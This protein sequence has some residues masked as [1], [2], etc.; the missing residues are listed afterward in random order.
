MKIIDLINIA[1]KDTNLYVRL[2][3]NI[4]RKL[5]SFENIKQTV[6]EL[7]NKLNISKNRIYSW[8]LENVAF[9]LYIGFD[10]ITNH[11]N[12][13]PWSKFCNNVIEIKYG[14]RSRSLFTKR[15]FPI[16][17]DPYYW[18]ILFA[19][20]CDGS[21][22]SW[23][24]QRNKSYITPSYTS[25]NKEIMNNF[26]DLVRV[27]FGKW[28]A[29]IY[30]GSIDIPP[31]ID[32]IFKTAHKINSFNTKSE[33]IKQ[34][35]LSKEFE[36]EIKNLEKYNKLAILI[37]FLV[38]EG[39]KTEKTLNPR[40]PNLTIS[41]TSKG[42][43][44]ILKIILS[45]LGINYHIIFRSRDNPKWKDL[46]TVQILRGKNR[47]NY[48]K[49]KKQIDDIVNNY[50]LCKL[51]KTQHKQL[52]LILNYKYNKPKPE[53]TNSKIPE[54]IIV[55]YIRNKKK[56]TLD[57][58]ITELKKNNL[59]LNI[60]SILAT[61]NKLPIKRNNKF[62]FHTQKLDVYIPYNKE[63]IKNANNYFQALK[64]YKNGNTIAD[65]SRSLN[66]PWSTIRD[67]VYNKSKPS[68]LFGPWKEVCKKRGLLKPI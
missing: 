51:T 1:K 43:L 8:K 34:F 17:K 14:Q 41:T 33:K 57:N 62:I 30:S 12:Y 13:I 20:F 19:L 38:D 16:K 6:P 46:Y 10:L 55:N 58:I 56:V 23:C 40:H 67:W 27:K 9:P 59:D 42:L 53:F 52:K 2:E 26:I 37:R 15:S 32:K 60:N 36:N 18:N 39:D 4:Q 64:L 22:D 29:K 49:L 65:I 68:L 3:P 66:K 35:K 11:S 47:E 44:K 61:L 25:H 31:V 7:A 24:S 45:D 54:Y 63:Q 48:R 28:S 50:P 21:S 5:F